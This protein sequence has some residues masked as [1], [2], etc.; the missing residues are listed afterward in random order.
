MSSVGDCLL[1]CL[2]EE[3][4]VH[5]HRAPRHVHNN[6]ICNYTYRYR[7]YYFL[8]GTNIPVTRRDY[9]PVF[10]ARAEI[11]MATAVRWRKSVTTHRRRDFQRVDLSRW[12]SSTSEHCRS[13]TVVTLSA[14]SY[15]NLCCLE[16][17]MRRLF[18]LNVFRFRKISISSH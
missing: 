3:H 13:T 12:A 11:G 17:K 6:T 8:A 5:R 18:A 4:T 10:T 16:V 7:C 2:D 1:R 9:E 14:S 15:V